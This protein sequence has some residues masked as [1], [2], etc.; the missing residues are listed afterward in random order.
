M[1]EKDALLKKLETS[2]LMHGDEMMRGALD[3][4]LNA[5]IPSIDIRRALMRGLEKV[6]HKLLSNDVSI[7]E[8]LFCIDTIT[9]GL[10]RLSSFQ[11]NDKAIEG[12]IP[13]VIG[14]VEGDPHDLGKNIIASNYRTCGYRVFDLG[15]YVPN[16][17]F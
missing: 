11:K 8:F 5:D 3:A 2:V 10:D 13:L 12:E 4:T 17:S 7:P 14:V 1:A 16:E 9:E 6:R 15:N